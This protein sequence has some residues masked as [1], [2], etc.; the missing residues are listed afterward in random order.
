MSLVSIE[1]LKTQL[2]TSSCIIFAGILHELR[3]AL[4]R[5][6]GSAAVSGRTAELFQVCLPCDQ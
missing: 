2:Q 6:N 5:G 1:L 3:Q 4:I